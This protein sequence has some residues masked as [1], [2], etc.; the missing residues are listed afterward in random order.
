MRDWARSVLSDPA[1]ALAAAVLVAGAVLAARPLARWRRWPA[2]PTLGL[3][4]A[5]ATVVVL[6]Q[7]PAPGHP[8]LGPDLGELQ[9]CARSLTSPRLLWTDGLLSTA[10][11]GERIGNIAMFVPLTLFAVVMTRRPLPVTAVGVLLPAAVEAAQALAGAG[12]TCAGFDWVNNAIGALLGVLL[13]LAALRLARRR[14]TAP[15]GAA[16][17]QEGSPVGSEF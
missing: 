12:R 14:T 16:A 9:A 3:L 6:T 2:L 5:A 13:G 10:N 1:T 4:L 15:A 7:L 17:S 8:V 11:R